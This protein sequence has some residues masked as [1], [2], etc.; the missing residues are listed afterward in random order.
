VDFLDQSRTSYESSPFP[1]AQI[2]YLA[3]QCSRPNV[4][5]YLLTA[6]IDMFEEAL[7]K[8]RDDPCLLTDKSVLSNVLKAA[9][10]HQIY[11]LVEETL[12]NLRSTLPLEWYSWLR[13][14]MIKGDREDKTIQRFNKLKKGYDSPDK[15]LYLALTHTRL[16]LAMLSSGGLTSKFKIA[17]RFVPLLRDLPPGALPTPGP[18][19]EWARQMLRK[20]LG[21]DGPRQVTQ[22]DGSSIVDMA[23][24]FDDPI[25]FLTEKYD[26]SPIF[27]Q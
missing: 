1:Q 22:D 11:E 5:D 12:A 8:L 10:R 2:N 26:F 25:R 24:Y 13:Q 16:T 17:T 20:V 21:G 19:M 6:M 14:W 18:I 9:L 7:P 3:K 23:L 27:S 15:T 4:Q